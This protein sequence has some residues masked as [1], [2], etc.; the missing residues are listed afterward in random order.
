MAEAIPLPGNKGI[1]KF[2][3]AADDTFAKLPEKMA[4]EISTKLKKQFG[5]MGNAIEVTADEIKQAR[6]DSNKIAKEARELQLQEMKQKLLEQAQAKR[7][8]KDRAKEGVG[9]VKALP[10]KG[11]QG[12]VNFF[13]SI[14]KG[15]KL[16]KLA[17]GVA[18]A[19]ALVL[20]EGLYNGWE[21]IKQWGSDAL[22]SIKDFF[23]FD[24]W[25]LPEW[26]TAEWWSTKWSEWKM[27]IPTWSEI[28]PDWTKLD[29]WSTKWSEW[30][31]NIPTW[32]EIRPDWTK[33]DWWTDMF[34]D[35]NLS[36]P[37]WESIRPEWAT[38]VWW[39][40]M[41]SDWNLSIPSWTDIQAQLPQWIIN[42]GIWFKGKF[43]EWALKLPTWTEIKE[44]FPSWLLKGIEWFRQKLLGWTINIPTWDEMQKVLP[45]WLVKTGKWIS[46]KF[47][48]WGIEIPSWDT[49][50]EKLPQWLAN[51]GDW[52]GEKFNAW[53]FELPT[54]KK[55][56]SGL[57]EFWDSPVKYIK[58]KVNG[59]FTFE[60]A[61]GE[62]F[63]IFDKISDLFDE[64]V[65]NPI[66]NMFDT[67][68]NAI[69]GLKISIYKWIE[70]KG[71][72]FGLDYSEEIAAA[73]A[74]ID[75]R[76]A[77]SNI[78]NATETPPIDTDETQVDN[79]DETQVDLSDVDSIPTSYVPPEPEY[80]LK[81]Y[82]A[83]A[84]NFK[85]LQQSSNQQGMRAF[86][87]GMQ[88][89]MSD[90]Q[91]EKLA[92]IIQSQSAGNINS[93]VDK[94]INNTIFND[95]TQFPDPL[96]NDF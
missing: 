4:E 25:S 52:I 65:Y 13:K 74:N 30:T 84:A 55:I 67:I 5:D 64:Y 2:F 49:I 66:M 77:A 35:W 78:R 17:W 41:F 87:S 94:S 42:A 1:E 37:T 24:N 22:Q 48:A 28:R 72:I 45:E 59:W 44:F 58:E 95:A 15:I 27:S 26:T 83:L 21:D 57:S 23:N 16:A 32:S 92:E 33:L 76:K 3:N 61:D 68:G 63:N 50:R 9:K 91:F 75:A 85:T 10:M 88:Q 54:W 8:L 56:K 71:K 46:D 31:F 90:D 29:W 60:G 18:L 34:S 81:D 19:G 7:S 14:G 79:T 20:F 96:A 53:K 70:D 39:T 6:K 86:L 43:D 82:K 80:T 89:G 12:I 73:Q 93:K 62:S 11:L 38:A 40:D 69:D 47:A 51:A 36:I